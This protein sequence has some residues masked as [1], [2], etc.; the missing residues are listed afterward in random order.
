M[1]T[2]CLIPK[3]YLVAAS[4]LLIGVVLTCYNAGANL[5][6]GSEQSGGSGADILR[7][8]HDEIPSIANSVVNS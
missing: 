3:R 5:R 2:N 7:S 6:R 8:E 4:L 1:K